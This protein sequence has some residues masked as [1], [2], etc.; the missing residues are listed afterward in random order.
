MLS[1]TTWP[2]EL[3]PIAWAGWQVA[4]SQEEKPDIRTFQDSVSAL[5]FQDSMYT[6]TYHICIYENNS[7]GERDYVTLLF[8]IKGE[9]KRLIGVSPPA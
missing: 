1:E 5:S 9:R 2:V 7:T 8:G 4:G 6:L 3:S